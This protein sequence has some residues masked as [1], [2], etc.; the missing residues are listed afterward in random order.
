[1][2]QSQRRYGR[3]RDSLVGRA[4]TRPAI[5]AAAFIAAV[6]GI[7]SFEDPY[8]VD[9]NL[10]PAEAGCEELGMSAQGC[11]SSSSIAKSSS[12]AIES[13]AWQAPTVIEAGSNEPVRLPRRAWQQLDQ[14]SV[15]RPGQTL[16]EICD[17]PPE[18]A[19]LHCRAHT[20]A[21]PSGFSQASKGNSDEEG[22]SISGHVV[23]AEGQTLEGV[24]I[25]AMAVR[26]DDD[27]IELSE[28]LRFWT[29]TDPLGAYEFRGLPAGEYAVRSARHGAYVPARISVRT[30]IDY[31]DLVVPRSRELVIKGQVVGQFDEP[32]DGITVFPTLLGQASVQTGLDGRF[33]LPV[34]VKPEVASL[35]LQFQAPGYRDASSRVLI[36]GYTEDVTEENKVVMD[37][38]ESWTTLEGTVKDDAERPLADRLVELRPEAGRRAQSTTTDKAGRYAFA[39]VESPAD[40]RLLLSGGEGFKDVERKIQVTNSRNEIDLI[41]EAYQTG[42][43]SGQLVNQD[44]SP[45]PDFE[46]VLKNKESRKPNTVV[47][48]DSNGYFEVAAAPAGDLVISSRS[49]PT[50]LIK[51]LR[52]EPGQ[53]IDL[54]MVLDWGGHSIRGQVVDS[55]GNPVAASRVILDWSHRDGDL[56]AQATR[57]TATD[58]LGRFAFSNL[59]PGPHSLKVDA[60]GFIGIDIE[61]D[62]RR[63]G[64]DVMVRLN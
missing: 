35:T 32:L 46:L 5:I 8:D 53:K 25:V 63:Q 12:S 57:R 16:V 29:L 30:G 9:G 42:A 61:H 23:S 6:G 19:V 26:L 4:I 14:T 59:G 13:D 38:V 7:L 56:D 49:T 3:G 55:T 64:Y 10:F 48:T 17:S 45:I 44:G 50:L 20:T 15:L 33:A 18:L 24:S 47:R 31:A 60:P 1:M 34:T 11:L 51:G 36:G 21:D 62:L 40:Y 37:V 2:E 54:P 43:I 52:L 28:N 22:S 41:V 58:P 27:A 39:F